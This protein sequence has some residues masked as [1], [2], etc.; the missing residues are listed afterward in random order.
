MD[1]ARGSGNRWHPFTLACAAVVVGGSIA[2]DALRTPVA[3]AVVFAVLLVTALDTAWRTASALLAHCVPSQRIAG[4]LLLFEAIAAGSVG[5][6]GAVGLFTLPVVAALVG[7]LHATAVL[8]LRP[9]R[10]LRDLLGELAFGSGANPLT[11]AALVAVLVVFGFVLQLQLRYTIQDADSMWY[12][13]VMAGSWVETGSIAPIDAIPLIGRAYPGFR[14]ALVAFAAL[15]FGHE[16]LALVGA[17]DFVLLALSIYAVARVAGSGRTLALAVAVYGT[18][19]PVVMGAFSTQGNDLSLA[20]HLLLSVLFLGRFLETG[21]RRKALLAGLALGALASIKFSGPGYAVIAAITAVAMYGWRRARD[22][23]ALL[24]LAGA[25]ALL[26]GPWYLRNLIVFGNP[27]YPARV[28]VGGHVLFG[29]PLGSDYFTPSTLGWNVRPLLDNLHHFPEAHGWL[30]PIVLLA[31]LALAAV[32]LRRGPRRPLLGLAL[33]PVLLFVAFLHHPFNAPWFDAGYTHRY[34]IVWFAGAMVVLAAAL[35]QLPGRVFWVLLLLATAFGGLTQV[36]GFVP[37][38]VA[39]VVVL[40]ASAIWFDLPDQADRL[41]AALAQLRLRS[42]MLLGIVAAAAWLVGERRAVW[43]YRDDLGYHD[44]VSERGWGPCA[45][46]VH[47]NVHGSRVGLH[48]SL[49]LFPLLGE[50]WSNT[51]LLADDLHLDVPR[52]SVA[53]VAAW[54]QAER[55]DWLCCCV[56]RLDR[57]GSRDYVFGESIAAQLVAARPDVFSVAFE[58]RG[59]AVL[60]VRPGPGR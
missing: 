60:Q 7:G 43:Q 29:G 4:A 34:L 57:T 20:S 32:A 2:G 11:D 58:S 37:V 9:P 36:T 44:A 41:L 53:E 59:A 49:Y 13:L 55:L 10:S 47:R 8:R 27:L 1:T 15:P 22:W 14:Q 42:A 51:V 30:V 17:F 48:G 24:Q 12:H 52:R 33:L 50:P 26:A 45:A 31:P 19:T 46:W 28:Q 6:C 38:M 18:T 3:A 25:A 56:P 54:A 16:H 39:A 40:T 35:A 23:R 5:L 21:D